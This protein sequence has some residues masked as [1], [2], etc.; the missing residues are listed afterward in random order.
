ME[1]VKFLY[2]VIAK[3]W[4]SMNALVRVLWENFAVMENALQLMCVLTAMT[5]MII[6]QIQL[7]N[8]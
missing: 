2:A 7:M 1:I 4:A 6:I 5:V 8:A 3:K